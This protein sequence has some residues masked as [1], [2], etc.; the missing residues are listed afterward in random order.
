[1]LKKYISNPLSFT[2]EKLNEVS[3]SWGIIK[4]QLGVFSP[5]IFCKNEP[6]N[7]NDRSMSV[8]NKLEVK[9]L[10]YIL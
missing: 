8:A 4:L 5:E 9:G 10:N 3:Y 2:I 7:D 1:M 6:G